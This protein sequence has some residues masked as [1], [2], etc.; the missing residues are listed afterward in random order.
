M[1]NILNIK[2]QTG[3]TGGSD[4]DYVGKAEAQPTKVKQTT[5]TP[6]SKSMHPKGNNTLDRHLLRR[7][8]ICSCI[9]VEEQIGDVV[10]IHGRL[11]KSS[12]NSRKNQQQ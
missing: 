11:C 3:T 12:D 8:G 6:S 4:E 9:V 7:Q 1:D 2:P 5:E 10:P